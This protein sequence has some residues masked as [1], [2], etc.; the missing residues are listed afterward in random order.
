MRRLFS[1]KSDSESA[2]KPAKPA[3]EGKEVKPKKTLFKKRTKEEQT[4][5]IT[6]PASTQGNS[7]SSSVA[8]DASMAPPAT[9]QFM[10]LPTPTGSASSFISV[11]SYTETTTPPPEV[12]SSRTSP[13]P[14]TL[15]RSPGSN[16]SISS[17]ASGSGIQVSRPA[18]SPL[19]RPPSSS[20]YPD[21][22]PSS[23]LS[24]VTDVHNL[25]TPPPSPGR[26]DSEFSVATG[27]EN[28]KRRTS[29]YN[30]FRRSQHVASNSA[31]SS[32][33]NSTTT[34]PSTCTAPFMPSEDLVPPPTPSPHMASRRSSVN[35]LR[36]RSV[37]NVSTDDVT[38][39]GMLSR[40]EATAHRAILMGDPL[41]GGGPYAY[42]GSALSKRPSPQQAA[43]G[44]APRPR[45]SNRPHDPSRRNSWGPSQASG[46][47]GGAV[48][49]APHI[50]GRFGGKMTI[51]EENDMMDYQAP[52]GAPRRN[53][54]V[55]YIED[56]PFQ[57]N[58]QHYPD[59]VGARRPMSII[60]GGRRTPS[61]SSSHQVQRPSH[62][63][64]FAP[65]PIM[66]AVG[67]LNQGCIECVW[68][69]HMKWERG[70]RKNW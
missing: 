60:A 7:S 21:R 29:I 19:S 27:D 52:Q 22:K 31:P 49:R 63:P 3:K 2:A 70:R 11:M 38:G 46:G 23:P 16:T 58:Q 67:A 9:Q 12:A 28:L 26:F 65:P 45:R 39:D 18:S 59:L 69:V 13:A 62:Y 4:A 61:R 25:P 30:L 44:P 8:S 15:T 1:R 6:P 37:I 48:W 40:N 43:A 64:P 66:G 47:N 20:G 14:S 10:G 51:E 53:S 24:V 34:L 33:S 32:R 35:F 50:G 36:R 68:G 54:P 5:V 42:P 55:T 56:T 57:G 17:M 41:G